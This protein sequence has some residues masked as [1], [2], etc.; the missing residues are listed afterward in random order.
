MQTNDEGTSAVKRRPMASSRLGVGSAIVFAISALPCVAAAQDASAKTF[1]DYLQPT[2]ITCPLTTNTWGC[3]AT[4]STPPNCVAGMGVVPRDTCN[5]IE[6]PQNP[7]EYYYWDGKIIRAADGTYHL[8]ADRWPGPNGFNPGWT[9]SD[10]IHAVSDGGALGPYTDMGYAYSY[11]PF[12]SD[13]H[14]GHNSMACTLNDGTYCLIASEVVPFTVFTS[15]S[16]DGPWTACPNPT[17]ELIEKNGV[18][19][20]YDGHLDSNVSIVPRPDGDFEIVQRHGLIAL[21]KTGICGPY[22]LQSPTNTYPANEQITDP[23]DSGASIYP[24]RQ[25]HTDPLAGKPG[26]PPLTPE[27]TYHLAEDPVIWF[28]G[29]RYHVVYDYPDDRVGYHLSSPDGIHDWTD[30]GLAYDPRFA[31]QIFSY[32]DGTIDHWYKMER[33]NV[34]M[35]N[36]HVTHITWAVSDVDKNDQI[37]AGSDHGSKVIVVPFEGALFDCE[38]GDGG[39]DGGEAGTD[40]GIGG[41]D[42]GVMD[43]VADAGGNQGGSSAS[44]GSGDGGAGN[45]GPGTGAGGPDSGT[46]GGISSGGSPRSPPGNAGSGCGCVVGEGLTDGALPAGGLVVALGVW[47]RTR[48]RKR[49]RPN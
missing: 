36:G 17:G 1:I 8:F 13:P 29:G 40:A 41:S 26:G 32:T 48:G 21:S 28:S 33:P 16:L 23:S 43:A 42:G 49:S 25:V 20:G 11:A 45:S 4:G 18:N 12:G 46:T 3:T 34:L 47:L 9:G 19:S 15:S 7:P 38:S 37:P 27:S 2:P 5:G 22:L 31:E 30:E 35:E 39:C 14:H 6:S 44:S 10:P 24:N